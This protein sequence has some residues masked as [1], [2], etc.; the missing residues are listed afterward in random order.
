MFWIIDLTILYSI[1]IL[2][3]SGVTLPLVI[4]NMP[5]NEWHSTKSAEMLDGSQKPP[6]WTIDTTFL[7]L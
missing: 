7:Y 3:P 4:A 5:I 1:H 6:H 2:M